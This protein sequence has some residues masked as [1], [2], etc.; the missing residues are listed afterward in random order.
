MSFYDR[1][2]LVR[3]T[4]IPYCERLILGKHNSYFNMWLTVDAEMDI[5][6]TYVRIFR[7]HFRNDYITEDVRNQLYFAGKNIVYSIKAFIYIKNNNYILEEL[8]NLVKKF[9]SEQL[10]NFE[11]DYDVSTWY[12]NDNIESDNIENINMRCEEENPT[13]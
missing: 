6:Y 3:E 13:C 12:N 8:L 10:D 7:E 2:Q 4:L 11:N 5:G 9:I 1:F